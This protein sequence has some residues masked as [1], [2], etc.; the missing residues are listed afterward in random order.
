MVSTYLYKMRDL[1]EIKRY[2]NRIRLNRRTIS[3][4]IWS[5]S[6]IGY[7]IAI[8]YED[9]FDCKIDKSCLLKTSILDGTIKLFS[10]E[11]LSPTKTATLEIYEELKNVEQLL[12]TSYYVKLLPDF[13]DKSKIKQYVLID[14]DDQSDISKIL[15]LASLIDSVLEC[16]EEIALGNKYKF[17]EI[18][19]I[20]IKKIHNMNFFMSDLFLAYGIDEITN[21]A[22]ANLNDSIKKEIVIIKK[23]SL[24]KVFFENQ[25]NKRYMLI[26]EF[27]NTFFKYIYEMRSLLEIER[28]QN[29]FRNKKRNVGQHEWSVSLISYLIAEAQINKTQEEINIEKLITTT[30]WHDD[31][32]M[33]SGD[34]LSNVKRVTPQFEKAIGNMEILFFEQYCKPNFSTRHQLMF[35]E[36]ILNPKSHTIEG[37]IVSVAD[38]IDTIFEAIEEINLGNRIEFEKVFLGGVNKLENIGKEIV[39]IEEFLQSNLIKDIKKTIGN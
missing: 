1:M 33:F 11:I 10:G 38:I 36:M 23:E 18:L 34:I 19:L 9:F 15:K 7:L 35:K 37:K 6:K 29:V 24:R 8:W 21:Y 4:H 22:F 3:D 32:E 30:L 27:N 31:I 12:Y 2:Q 26:E 28:Y 13:V 17:D 25:I 14:K 5:T 16:L 20:L 39:I